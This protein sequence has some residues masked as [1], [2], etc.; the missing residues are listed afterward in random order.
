M[1]AKIKPVLNCNVDKRCG[2]C[3]VCVCVCVC[4]LAD[5]AIKL[6]YRG[7]QNLKSL[8]RLFRWSSRIHSCFT[9]VMEIEA[10]STLDVTL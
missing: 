2:L 7:K 3:S 8:K 1:F 4:V 10:K 9:V 6:R 5:A